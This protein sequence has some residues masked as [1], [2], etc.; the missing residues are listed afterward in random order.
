[1]GRVWFRLVA[2][3]VNPTIDCYFTI[4]QKSKTNI[5]HHRHHHHRHKHQG[6]YSLIRC[7]SRVTAA[8][9]NVSSVF[10]L[11][12]FP[13]VCIGMISKGFDFEA[14]FASVEAS[15]VCIRLSCLIC[16]WSVVRCVCSPLF[17]GHNGFSLPEVSVTSF[18]LLQFFDFV[19][20]L[21]SNFLTHV[22]M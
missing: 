21:K 5:H 12:S 16:P 17:C 13:V 7:V 20:L 4:L 15:S 10:Q 8:L 11:F 6:L 22:K 18:L 2:T 19:R 1:M 3:E 9:A 14:F